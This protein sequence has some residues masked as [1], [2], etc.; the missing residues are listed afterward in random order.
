MHQKQDVWEEHSAVEIS[1]KFNEMLEII[2]N[3]ILI[4]KK[5][6][7]E[8]FLLI[9]IFLCQD[10]LPSNNGALHSKIILQEI[11]NI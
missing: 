5:I 3:V 7:N 10:I 2:V 11:L 4:I 8:L 6:F 1:F 9:Q